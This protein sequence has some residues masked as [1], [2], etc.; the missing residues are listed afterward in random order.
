MNH[1][2]TNSL[3]R[4]R[5]S[6]VLYGNNKSFFINHIVRQYYKRGT[7]F[8]LVDTENS[9]VSVRLRIYREERR[10]LINQICVAQF[11]TH[12]L[13]AENFPFICD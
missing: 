4:K 1:L 6:P 9:F 3:K 7:H 10:K 11:Y 12:P 5:E 8:V 2:F 13:M